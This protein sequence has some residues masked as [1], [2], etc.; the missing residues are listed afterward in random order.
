MSNF[1]TF[2]A[3]QRACMKTNCF[4]LFATTKKH[5]FPL[6]GLSELGNSNFYGPKNDRVEAAVGGRLSYLQAYSEGDG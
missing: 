4:A 5:T 3:L 6:F 1:I 2:L